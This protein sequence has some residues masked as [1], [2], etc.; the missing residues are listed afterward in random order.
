VEET[1]PMSRRTGSVETRTSWI[2]ATAAL[3]VLSVSYGAPLT[4]VVALKPIA[5]EF[6]AV[7]SAPALAVSLTFIGAGCG[8]IAWGWLAERIGVRAV[9]MF[10]ATMIGAGLT[11]ASQ[12]G[13]TQL[14]VASFL[15]VGLLGTATMFAPMMT[16][17][18][19]WFDVRRGSA[20]ALISAGQYIAGALWPAVFQFGIDTIGWRHTMLAYAGLLVLVILPLAALFLRRPP[21]APVLGAMH[22][23][24]RAGEPVL[25]LPPNLVLAAL[26]FAT[27]CCCVTMS[28]PMAHMVAFCSDIGIAPT[29]GAAMLSVLLGSAFF[30]RQFWGW[31]ADRIGGLRTILWASAAQAAAM[32]GFLLTQDEIG[33]FTISAVFGFG[34][35]GLIPGYVLAVRELFPA[36]EASWRIPTMMFPG[37]FG[38]AAGGWLAG[39][40]YDRLGFYAPAF[41][42][43]VLFNLLNL[44]VIGTLVARHRPRRLAPAMV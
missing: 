20:I 22:A 8:G 17:V 23:G 39:V 37:S 11:I 27:F 3:I 30:A 21:E 14:Y 43:G 25:G 44:A 40:M 16:Y 42:I 13:L 28:M 18:S 32:A 29:Q 36:S 31:L 26:A 24:P 6:G 7:R 35:G 2:V 19:R 9:V 15:L 4:T 10:G 41:A 1:Q 38:M 5:E 12:G 34:F 33:L